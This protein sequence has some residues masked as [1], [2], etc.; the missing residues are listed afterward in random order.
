MTIKIFKLLTSLPF[1]S[2]FIKHTECTQEIGKEIWWADF[3]TLIQVA[4]NLE[5][6]DDMVCW[7]LEY[8]K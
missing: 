4:V 1:A 8:L 7:V 2:L 6:Y 5:T 3:A